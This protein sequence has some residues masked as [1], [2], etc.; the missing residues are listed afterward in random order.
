MA[1]PFHRIRLKKESVF[2]RKLGFSAHD[3]PNVAT[4]HHQAIGKLGAGLSAT[5]TSLDGK[6]VE[7]VEHARFTNVLGIQFH[8]ERHTLYRKGF[9]QRAKTGA[10]LIFNPLAFLKANPPTYAFHLAIWKWFAEQVAAQK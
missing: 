7:A 8:P 1:Y 6:I 4:A 10:P 2:V 9:F 5:A 3:L